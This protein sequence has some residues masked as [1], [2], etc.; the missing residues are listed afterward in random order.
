MIILLELRT[1]LKKHK[2]NAKVGFTL[3][4]IMI[5]VAI[6]GLLAAVAIP[7]FVRSRQTSQ[8]NACINNLR[9]IDAAKKQWALET[10][11]QSGATPVSSNIV[12]YIGR[13]GSIMPNCPL[14]GSGYVIGALSTVPVCVNFN[15]NIHNAVYS[16]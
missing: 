6:T 3:L 2:P 11:Q 13:G 10:C 9:I 12:A 16:R 5:V 7:N 1:G 14:G 15:T 4:E 8:A